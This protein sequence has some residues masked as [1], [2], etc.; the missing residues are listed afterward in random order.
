[1]IYSPKQTLKISHNKDSYVEEI[2]LSQ[3]NV[4]NNIN[5]FGVIYFQFRLKQKKLSFSGPYDLFNIKL[6]APISI[7][8]INHCIN[9]LALLTLSQR[10]NSLLIPVASS[11]LDI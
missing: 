6:I 9:I 10:D 4:K 2:F 5:I 3:S 7:K 1:M 8:T 11:E